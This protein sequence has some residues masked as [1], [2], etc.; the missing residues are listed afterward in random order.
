MASRGIEIRTKKGVTVL[1]PSFSM[2]MS[3]SP[4]VGVSMLESAKEAKTA[5]ETEKEKAV[6]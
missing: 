5:V 4:L 2:D 6:R 1:K 3:A